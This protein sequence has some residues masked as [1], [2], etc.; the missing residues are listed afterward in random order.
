MKVAMHWTRGDGVCRFG[1]ALLV[2]LIAG[3]CGVDKQEA[4]ALGGP[5]GFAQSI[6]LTATPDRLTQ[7]GQ[8]QVVVTA[9]ARDATGGP[10]S[11][12]L[13]RWNVRASDGTFIEPAP[14]TT[15]TD[16]NGRTSTTVTAP[17]AP[18]TLPNSPVSLTIV[19]TPVGSDINNANSMLV[20]VQLI[21]PVGTLPAPPPNNLP[22]AL[23]TVS[24]A[25][26]RLNQTVTF[27][28]SSTTDE[29]A[30][31]GAACTYEWDFGD[32]ATGTGPIV[33]HEYGLDVT[34]AVTVTLTVTDARGG[35]GVATRLLSIAVPAAPTPV[36]SFS[37]TVPA[38]GQTI[39]FDAGL[40]TVGQGATIESYTWV[41]GDG[42]ENTVSP[43]SQSTHSYPVEGTFVVRLTIRDSLGRSAST[44]GNVSVRVPTTTP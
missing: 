4:P 10:I 9:V 17:P 5:S 30:L 20:S 24:P 40:S 15:V 23:F 19:A 29:G 18:A 1:A 34:G 13:I 21:P 25:N 8:S 26:P 32:G 12:L 11:G 37:P 6:M 36:I 42:T 28:A 22:V 35:V 7:D 43:N 2:G 39:S 16:T 33:T 3:A 38:P 44:S 27:N 31:C 14:E 41:W